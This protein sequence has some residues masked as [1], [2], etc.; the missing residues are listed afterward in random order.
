M[1]LAEMREPRFIGFLMDLDEMRR[2]PI[3][4]WFV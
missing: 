2:K 3:G 1:D 4:K